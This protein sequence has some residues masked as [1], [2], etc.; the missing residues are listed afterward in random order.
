MIRIVETA[1]K[2]E[3]HANA[4]YQNPSNIS[5]QIACVGPRLMYQIMEKI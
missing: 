5:D 2:V 3:Y 4:K 1:V